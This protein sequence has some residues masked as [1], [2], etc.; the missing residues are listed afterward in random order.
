MRAPLIHIPMVDSINSATILPYARTR[1]T[2]AGFRFQLTSKLKLI[3]G[4]FEIQ[5]PYFNFDP[6]NVDRQLGVQRASGVEL[7]LSGETIPNLDIAMGALLGEVKIIGS[8]LLAEGFG[9]TALGQPHNYETINADYKFPGCWR[10]AR[11][12]TFYTWVHIRSA[13]MMW[14]N[15][16]HK[17]YS[18]WVAAIDSISW[19]LQRRCESKSKMPPIII[20]WGANFSPG[21]YQIQP[22]AHFAN[23]TADI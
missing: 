17:Q 19:A 10:C 9:T 6:N 12:S 13:L 8:S 7:S 23:L 14:C 5:K 20:S 18:W 21:F 1:Q 4:V 16:L 15:C 22:R 11:T 2:D 3:A